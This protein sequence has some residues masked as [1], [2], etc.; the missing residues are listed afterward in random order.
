S[1]LISL[2][3]TP[4]MCARLLKAES[5]VRHS[6]FQI[7][8]GRYMDRLTSAYDTGLKWVLRHQMLTLWVALGTFLLTALLYAMVPKGFFPQQDT[9]L[10]QAISQ[11]PQTV[12]FS[13]M[14]QRQHNAVERILEDPD[15]PAVTSF[16]GIDWTNATLNTGRMQIAL[17]PIGE[18]SDNVQAIIDRLGTRLD[19]L[20]DIQVFMQPVQDLT[21]DDRVS[22]T[23]Y[24]MTLSDPDHALLLEW[25]PRLVDAL[26]DVPELRDV[27]DDLQSSGLQATVVIDRDAAERLGISNAMID[28]ALYDAFGQRLI[29]TIF[30]QSSQYRVVLEVAPQFRQDPQALEQIHIPTASGTPVPLS[31]VARI[32]QSSTLLSIERLG[33]FPATTISFNLAH[34]VALS[35][36]VQAIRTAQA[37][38]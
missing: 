3:L 9:G 35:D 6:R 19:K 17:K 16:I 22:R 26:R 8:L 21:V 7:A 12:S 25:T 13:S 4:M 30:T 38:L 29:S 31:S 5:E 34:G 15:V 18:R 28:D 23:Q 27:V 10:I 36:A 2:T 14:A 1:L 37:E 33:Q 24:Q 32:E 11:G 20:T